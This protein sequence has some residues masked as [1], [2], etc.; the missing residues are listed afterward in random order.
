MGFWSK[1]ALLLALCASIPCVALE[2]E[3]AEGSESPYSATGETSDSQQ[4]E[5]SG[6]RPLNR[7]EGSAF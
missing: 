1:G 3:N 6:F 2:S 5:P 4:R 7:N